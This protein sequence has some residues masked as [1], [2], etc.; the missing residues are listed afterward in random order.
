MD[1]LTFND[2]PPFFLGDET[3]LPENFLNEFMAWL[4][5]RG[6]SLKNVLDA[7]TPSFLIDQDANVE[8]SILQ[9]GLRANYWHDFYEKIEILDTPEARF[10]ANAESFSKTVVSTEALRDAYE[11]AML[12]G[13]DIIYSYNLFTVLSGEYGTIEEW[14]FDKLRRLPEKSDERYDIMFL[15][16]ELLPSLRRS[17]WNAVELIKIPAKYSATRAAVPLLRRTLDQ[18]MW[19]KAK[20]E[21]EVLEA[22][23][24]ENLKEKERAEKELQV[25]GERFNSE[26]KV[27]F[28]AIAAGKPTVNQ[29]KTDAKSFVKPDKIPGVFVQLSDGRA[30]LMVETPLPWYTGSVKRATQNFVTWNDRGPNSLLQAISEALQRPQK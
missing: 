3:Q 28:D 22:A 14:L 11:R 5:E 16:K 23:E 24:K 8:E 4:A 29:L 12:L 26:T 13:M 27:I 19:E 25:A 15:L 6:I 20:L 7:T 9:S 18:Y 2:T 21:Q 30:I 1:V 10:R 17:G